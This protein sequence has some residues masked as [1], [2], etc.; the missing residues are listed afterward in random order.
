MSS[1]RLSPDGVR[2][3]RVSAC[4]PQLLSWQMVDAQGRS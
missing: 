4:F 1:P 2:P 3:R